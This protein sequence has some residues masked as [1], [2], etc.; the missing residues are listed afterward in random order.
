MQSAHY[1]IICEF[2]ENGLR[3]VVFD[4]VHDSLG[5]DCFP[6]EEEKVHEIVIRNLTQPP[7]LAKLIEVLGRK[8]IVPLVVDLE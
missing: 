1:G 8:H 6:G 4:Q 7:L 5:I 3:S 2:L